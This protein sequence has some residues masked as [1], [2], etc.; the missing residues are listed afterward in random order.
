M[1]ATGSVP[2]KQAPPGNTEQALRLLT[3]I[4]LTGVGGFIDA[5]SYLGLGRVFTAA[6]TGNS[7]LLALAVVQLDGGSALRSSIA[8]IGFVCGVAMGEAVSGRAEARPGWPSAVGAGLGLEV[9]VLAAAAWGWHVAGPQQT[10]LQ[11][12]LLIALSAAAMGIQSVTARQLGVAAVTTTYVTGTVTSLTSGAVTWLRR[13]EPGRRQSA[14][15]AATRSD[16]AV[17]HGP[18]LP[19]LAWAVYVVG[20]L[21]GGLV[22]LTAPSLAPLPALAVLAL[23]LVAIRCAR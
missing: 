21:A 2:G 3:L 15:Q 20:A 4:M 6:M 19:A 1:T 13:P 18:A 23:L 8:L 14:E 17:V 22:V 16:S 9:F 7:I 5:V 11:Q 12:H 10:G